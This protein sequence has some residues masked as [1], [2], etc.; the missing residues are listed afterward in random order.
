MNRDIPYVPSIPERIETMFE[1]IEV[2]P[3]QKSLDLGAGDGRV[4]IE[5]AKRGL[6][7]IGIEID[8][9]LVKLA[10]KNIKEAGLEEKVQVFEKDFWDEDFSK[11]D[12]ITIYGIT[13]IMKRLEEKFEHELKP[14]TLVVSN[15][16]RLPY[17]EPFAKHKFVYAYKKSS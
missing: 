4:V 9:N 12:V 14:G 10:N 15:G 1:L 2:S 5:F 17:W 13:D 8:P 3:G 16:F 11:Y 7:A 6:D